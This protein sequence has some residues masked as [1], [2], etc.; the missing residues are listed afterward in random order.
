MS[1]EV[2][3]REAHREE[4]R[5]KS[6]PLPADDLEELDFTFQRSVKQP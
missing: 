2:R 1:A 3:A 5:I 4:N 6:A